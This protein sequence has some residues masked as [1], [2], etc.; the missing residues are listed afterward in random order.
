MKLAVE[1]S[2]YPLQDNYLLPIKWFIE[3]L[4]AYPEIQ[5]KTNAMSTQLLGDY[6]QV[7]SLLAVEMKAAHE[8][9]GKGVFVCKFIPGGVNLDHSE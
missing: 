5:R 3:R 7:M 4:D 2:L 9:W 6:D 8:K 1:I